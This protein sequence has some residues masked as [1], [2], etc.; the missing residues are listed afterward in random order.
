MKVN[1]FIQFL[2]GCCFQKVTSPTGTIC[3]EWPWKRGQ[4]SIKGLRPTDTPLQEALHEGGSVHT[5]DWRQRQKGKGSLWPE[6]LK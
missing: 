5:G 4:N 6:E 3:F 1:H 2:F